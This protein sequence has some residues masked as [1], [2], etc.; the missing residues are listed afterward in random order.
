MGRLTLFERIRVIYL[1]NLYNTFLIYQ[2]GNMALKF[3]DLV[4]EDWLKNGKLIEN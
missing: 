1:F 3:L 2:I 4:L